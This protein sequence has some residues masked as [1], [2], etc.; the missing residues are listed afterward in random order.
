[1]S[2]LQT[3]IAAFLSAAIGVVVAEA[4]DRLLS[5]WVIRIVVEG[6]LGI[7]AGFVAFSVIADVFIYRNLGKK[8]EGQ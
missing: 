5:V 2:G 4:A 7:A 3:A 8:K 6:M 1:M